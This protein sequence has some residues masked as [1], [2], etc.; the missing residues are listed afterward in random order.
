[1]KK[2][3]LLLIVGLLFSSCGENKKLTFCDCSSIMIEGY[4]FER[5]ITEKEAEKY[6]KEKYGKNF[7]SNCLPI[8]KKRVAESPSMPMEDL[9][10]ECEGAEKLFNELE[11]KLDSESENN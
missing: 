10:K 11:K 2:F 1:M 9:F 3:P 6:I 5:D 4:F 8:I 7:R